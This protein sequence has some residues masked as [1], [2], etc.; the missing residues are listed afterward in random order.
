MI[1]N[2]ILQIIKYKGINRRKFYI[3]T[4]LSNGFLDKVKD[5]GASKIEQILH[6]YPE[7]SPE[8]LLTGKGHML[9][10]AA[11]F[12]YEWGIKMSQIEEPPTVYEVTTTKTVKKQFVP[13]YDV[14]TSAGAVSLF[15]ESDQK[16]IDYVS[17]PN[18]A[19][20][21]GAVYVS[22]ESMYPLLKSGDLII[23]KKMSHIADHII[24]GEMYLVSIVTEDHEEFLL[25]RWI[26]KSDKGDDWIKL[27]SENSHHQ[28]KEVQL[29]N[30][31]GLALIKAT[32]RVNS[33]F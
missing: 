24:W 8:W 31:E 5:V 4:G 22:G 9:E 25:I 16:P 13:V 3:E 30:I 19:K 15:K 2:R 1:V 12:E 27:V 14:E 10:N 29:K 21:D 33:T 18:L 28:P 26:Q 6:S 7:I 17:V 20:C 23:Y 32:I 11:F